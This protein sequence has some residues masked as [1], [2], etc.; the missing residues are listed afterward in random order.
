MCIAFL[1]QVLRKMNHPNIIKLKEVIKENNE[2][3]FIFE[4]MVM[5][6]SIFLLFL[7]IYMRKICLSVLSDLHLKKEKNYELL[8]NSS[9]TL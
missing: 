9:N 5:K 6:L 3:F 8:C 7:V 2:L 1:L 4:Y